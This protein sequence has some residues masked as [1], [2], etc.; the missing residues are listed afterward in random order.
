MNLYF[1]ELGQGQPLVILHGLFGSS[2]NWFTISKQFAEHFHVFILDQRNHGQSPHTPL[3]NY[4]LMAAD[5]EEFL[6][7][8]K[9]ENP[10][11]IGHSMGG[12]TVIKFLT[13]IDVPIKKAI[14]VDISPR[15]YPQHHQAYIKA[16]KSLDLVTLSS[17]QAVEQAFIDNGVSNVGE[18][19]FLMKN[20]YRDD[21]GAF[22]WKINLDTLMSEIE[23]IGEG[24]S[25]NAHSEVPVLFIKGGK[26]DY[27]LKPEDAVLIH[28][29]FP[30]SQ[31]KTTADAGHWI[32]AEQPAA[33][34]TMVMDFIG[35]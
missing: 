10:I 1:K 22:H 3:H 29:I 7:Q 25:A 32:Q 11:L 28:Q 26:S 4:D 17:R 21:N 16:M 18:R 2:D 15:Y 31:I 30:H 5:L 14:I 9:I 20:L 35:T 13:T 27:Y 33:F 8:N 34:F 23:N 12:K 24:T 19:Q 6:V